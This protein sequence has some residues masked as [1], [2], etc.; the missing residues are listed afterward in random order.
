MKKKRLALVEARKAI[1]HSHESIAK[2]L[3]IS[4]SEYTH[5]ENAN[6][7]PSAKVIMKLESLFPKY[8][9]TDLLQVTEVKE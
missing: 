6:R 2:L 1:N 8:K 7:T 5:Y 9:I 4:K 3:E